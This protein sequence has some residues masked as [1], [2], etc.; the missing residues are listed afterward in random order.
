MSTRVPT[1]YGRYLGRVHFVQNVGGN[2]IVEN[3][4]V[5]GVICDNIINRWKDTVKAMITNHDSLVS[6][7]L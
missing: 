3:C 5:C 6:C 1:S 4:F 2:N 7:S